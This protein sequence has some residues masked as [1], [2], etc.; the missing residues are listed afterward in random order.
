[1]GASY[2]GHKARF[3]AAAV[4]PRAGKGEYESRDREEGRDECTRTEY[5]RMSRGTAGPHHDTVLHQD[6]CHF[7]RI[8]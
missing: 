4:L 8:G 5:S 1:M 7:G 3:A 2:K 6:D